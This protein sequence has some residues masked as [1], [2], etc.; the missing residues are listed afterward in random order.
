MKSLILF[1]LVASLG[2][3]TTGLVQ[4]ASLAGGTPKNACV[5]Y[6]RAFQFGTYNYR[7]SN[8]AQAETMQFK[9]G[10]KGW[11]QAFNEGLREGLKDYRFSRGDYS[12]GT[13]NGLCPYPSY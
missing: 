13:G 1:G 4:A 6:D 3:A 11:K 5:C 7:P 2:F 9:C 10:L 12:R 8:S